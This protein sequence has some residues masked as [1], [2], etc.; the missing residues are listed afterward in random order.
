MSIPICEVCGKRPAISLSYFGDRR[1][2][3]PGGTWKL[4]CMCTSE[5]E[6]YYIEFE[7]F[8][9]EPNWLRHLR[10][11]R[12]FDEHDFLQAVNRASLADWLDPA[13]IA[14]INDLVDNP[15]FWR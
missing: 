1:E 2:K 10:T 8:V 6:D 12:W 14:E 13:D 4:A 5:T 15:P 9:G 11:K 3:L 7:R